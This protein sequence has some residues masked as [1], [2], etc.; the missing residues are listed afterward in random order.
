METAPEPTAPEDVRPDK[1]EHILQ[2]AEAARRAHQSP[3]WKI[4]IDDAVEEHGEACERLW[5]ELYRLLDE[6]QAEGKPVPKWQAPPDV[7]QEMRKKITRALK[8]DLPAMIA[9]AVEDIIDQG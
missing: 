7:R 1:L 3:K 2:L 8:A 6:R 4:A 5:N 9:A